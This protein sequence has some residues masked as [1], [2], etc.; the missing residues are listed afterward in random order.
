MPETSREVFMEMRERIDHVLV[1]DWASYIST[2]SDAYDTAFNN[3]NKLLD[4]VHPFGPEDA[5]C[6]VVRGQYGAGTVA[7]NSVMPY[8]SA[9]NVA[10]DSVTETYVALKLM[11]DN[12]RWAGVPIYLRTGKALARRRSEVVIRFK[13]APFALFRDTLNDCL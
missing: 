12:W 11:M 13:Q 7:G 6:N 4:A 2:M 5:R 9:P 3:V 8:R 10:P 1:T